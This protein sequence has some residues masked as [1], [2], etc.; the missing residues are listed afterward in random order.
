MKLRTL[1]VLTV[2]GFV[3]AC[4]S[5]EQR[6]AKYLEKA[7]A[8]FEAGDLIKSELDAKNTLQIEPQNAKARFLLARIAETKLLSEPDSWRNMMANLQRVIELEPDHAE[9]RVKLIQLYLRF[10][11]TPE[12]AQLLERIRTELDAA[13]SYAPNDDSVRALTP[14]VEY[15][16]AVYADDNSGR[17]TALAN[18]QSLFDQDP[19]NLLITSFLAGVHAIQDPDKA[20]DYLDT[21]LQ[22]NPQSALRILKIGLLQSQNR[23]SDAE[24]EYKTLLDEYP[25]NSQLRLGLAKFYVDSDRPAKAEEL[26]REIVAADPDDVE[27][28]MRLVRFVGQHKG[29]MEAEFLVQEYVTENPEEWKYR[30]L[31][32]EIYAS[33]DRMGD[34]ETVFLDIIEQAGTTQAGLDARNR[35]A[36]MRMLQNRKGEAQEYLDEVLAIDAAN[37]DALM[38]QAGLL[39]ERGDI[40]SA[41]SGL[42][43]VLRNDPTS[44]RGLLVMARAHSMAGNSNLA[45][46]NYQKLLQAHPDNAD[47]RRELGRLLMRD[48]QWEEAR[49]VLLAGV[50]FFPDDLQM[51][52]MLVDTLVRVSDW[53]AAGVQADRLMQKEQTRGLGHYLQGRIQQGTGAIAESIDSFK[54]SIELEPNAIEPLTN[55]VRSYVVTEQLDVGRQYLEDFQ[56]AQPQNVHSQTLIAEVH[57]RLGDMDRAIMENDK[58]LK[59]NERWV[60]AYRNLIGLHLMQGDVAAAEQAADGALEV[61]PDD[62]DLR[63][64]R[65]TVYER[66]NRFD[67]AIDIYKKELERNPGL[68]VAVNNYAALVADHRQEQSGPALELARRFRN[69]ENPIF[70]DTLGWLLYRTGDL[71][72]A[73]E[74]L[75]EAVAGAQQVPQL[76]YHLGMVYFE[77]D[78]LDVA[79]REL[80]AAVAATQPYTGLDT[81]RET[82]ELL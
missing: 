75:E 4:T 12:K 43:T 82:L 34:A 3:V 63:M 64:L 26:M 74:V 31:L 39:I 53:E 49:G 58:A 17:D 8:S 24:Q 46:E 20:L 15:H 7:H 78:R 52:R 10:L 14:V 1:A 27:A 47:G 76:R 57:A 38:M 37:S 65:A 67:E 13:V 70:L 21:S 81:A 6:A 40:E 45:K 72:A 9:A 19:G 55:L 77:L 41:I 35:M 44:K 33:Q 51:T 30:F 61:M 11:G 2:L 73:V 71:E 79:K 28:R 18:A 5:A 36:Q 62:S 59:I 32:S 22:A 42:R 54:K 48:R 16:E 80:Q 23:I 68:D 50:D 29:M 25:D 69:S 66:Q 60:P 56:A